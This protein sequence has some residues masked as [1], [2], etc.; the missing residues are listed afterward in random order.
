LSTYTEATF[1]GYAAVALTRVGTPF[2]NVAGQGEQDF[3]LGNFTATDGVVP[4]TIYGYYVTNK[5]GAGAA[6][7][8]WSERFSAPVTINA[9]GQQINVAPQLTAVSAF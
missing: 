8:V 4:N 9:G 5:I 1:D 7:L 6:T 3:Q 2:I